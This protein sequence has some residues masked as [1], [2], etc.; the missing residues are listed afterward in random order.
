MNSVVPEEM[1][2]K[3]IER[4]F[5]EDACRDAR[6]RLAEFLKTADKQIMESRDKNE[7]RHRGIRH[8][9]IKTLMGTVPVER[10]YYKR[11][12]EDGGT[13]RVFLL[14]KELGFNTTGTISPNLAEK[15]ASHIC[16]MTYREVAEAVSGLTDQSITPQGTWNLIQ[17]I[18]ERQKEAEKELMND[19]KDGNLC[20]EKV[21]P[22]IFEEA[23]GMMVS[24]QERNSKKRK[25][26]IELK[27]GIMYEGWEER[28][29]SSKEYKTVN[30][31]AFA[32]FMKTKD[33][34]CLRESLLAEKYET[35]SI[36]HR[37]LNGDGASWIKEDND[38][39]AYVMQLDQFHIKKAIVRNV[40]DKKARRYITKELREGHCGKVLE[41]IESLKHECGGEVKEVK[42]L[43][44]LERYIRKNAEH[45]MPYKEREGINLPQS[46]EGVEYRTLGTMEKN[47]SIF[48][49]RFKG[50]KSWSRDGA[51]N[52]AKII[53]LKMGAGFNGKIAGLVSGRVSDK[54][55]E[56]FE[57][58][59]R[60]T[61]NTVSKR[62]TKN[63]YQ[64][65][66]GELPFS[67]CYT[68]NGRKAIRKMFDIKPF[69]EMTYR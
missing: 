25:K 24:L 2:F 29:L 26:K 56:R 41:K 6:N 5:Y 35:D 48:A 10:A 31:T 68:T 44:D 16:E 60:N 11:I 1:T 57:E 45:V 34:K 9:S 46:P 52:L 47:I 39:A 21:M 7:Y 61:T 66:R 50:G 27:A 49:K 14:D 40:A 20:G 37:I 12:L 38:D 28:Y 22:V 51:E 8:T 33:F 32:G 13:E 62:I 3:D 59:V 67:N 65:H 69:T 23:D 64:L 55:V 4:N 15:M 30:K 43:R 58:E 36:T 53:A 17:I 19:F 63:V 18:G 42:K 54:M